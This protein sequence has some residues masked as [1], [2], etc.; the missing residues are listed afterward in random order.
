MYEWL[1]FCK[2]NRKNL[3]YIDDHPHTHGN[4]VGFINSSMCSLIFA[5]CSF[6]KQ[7]NGQD[8]FMEKKAYKF[9]VVHAM[10]SLS[11]GDELLINYN[12]C[13]PPNSRQNWL[14]LGLALDV[15]FGNKK[16]IIN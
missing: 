2:F 7:F 14:A 16:K 3:L 11:P 8:F 12:F 13:R 10:R 15:S 6:E 1:H 4:I 9:V 5:N